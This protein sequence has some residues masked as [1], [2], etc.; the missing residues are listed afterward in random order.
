[1]RGLRLLSASSQSGGSSLLA[2]LISFTKEKRANCSLGVVRLGG[3]GDDA[4]SPL[5]FTQTKTMFNLSLSCFPKS[6]AQ[7]NEFSVNVYSDPPNK[8]CLTSIS[9]SSDLKSDS[10]L[11]TD[12][13]WKGMGPSDG[14]TGALPPTPSPMSEHRE[15]VVSDVGPMRPPLAGCHGRP[16]PACVGL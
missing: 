2:G 12:A 1:M 5:P 13:P 3:S 11:K 6:K 15:L 7:K 9:V 14:K 8:M 10:N 4:T 16:W